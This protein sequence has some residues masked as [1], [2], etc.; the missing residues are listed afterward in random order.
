M[1]TAKVSYIVSAYAS[2]NQMLLAPV[3]GQG[4]LDV[5]SAGLDAAMAVLSQHSR[6]ALAGDDAADDRLPAQS[7][8]F[9]KHLGELDVHLHTARLR[10]W[11][12]RW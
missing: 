3:V 4:M 11:G 8:D 10:A 12:A 9:G 7:H 5:G 2:T 6:V 1:H